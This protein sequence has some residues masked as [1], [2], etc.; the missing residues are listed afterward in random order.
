MGLELIMGGLIEDA[1]RWVITERNRNRAHAT[2]LDKRDRACL[3]VHFDDEILDRV[4]LVTVGRIRNPRFIDKIKKRGVP[5]PHDFSRN[6]AIC[7]SDTIVLSRTFRPPQ[8]RRL[9]VLFHQLVHV[10]QYQVLGI[11]GFV[12]RYMRGWAA[13]DWDYH[14]IPLE[15]EAYRLQARFEETAVKQI[16]TVGHFVRRSLAT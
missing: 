6:R 5:V 10:V 1:R 2:P 3:A 7:F 4:R 14:R 8:P 13:V 11:D 15:Q 12:E 16:F 9:G